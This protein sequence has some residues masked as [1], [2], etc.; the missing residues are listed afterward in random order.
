MCI[1]AAVCAASKLLFLRLKYRRLL[2]TKPYSETLLCPQ[3]TPTL[4]P[5]PV[6]S[7]NVFPKTGC[8]H[9]AS[10]TGRV[11]GP[12]PGFS[13][14]LTLGVELRRGGC[15]ASP[16]DER[17]AQGHHVFNYTVLQGGQRISRRFILSDARDNLTRCSCSRQCVSNCA[18][19]IPYSLQSVFK[20][21]ATKLD[22]PQIFIPFARFLSRVFLWRDDG[23][24][25]GLLSWSK[26]SK[27]SFLCK[28]GQSSP[29]ET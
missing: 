25:A 24:T 11:W 4:V 9:G 8:E 27:P 15:A 13:P 1:P 12:A 29:I 17:C 14:S 20:G 3:T 28:S 2:Q 10:L 6:W 21:M 7:C 5:F 23:K 19:E 22:S 26:E 16:R 18:Q